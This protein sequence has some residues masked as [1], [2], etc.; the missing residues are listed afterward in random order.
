MAAATSATDFEKAKAISMKEPDF[1][2]MALSCVLAVGD[3]FAAAA[4][5]KA[6]GPLVKAIKNGNVS[7]ALKL[8]SVA[9]SAG[10]K[11]A[12]KMKIVGEAVSELSGEQIVAV[13][14]SM[15]RSSGVTEPA[16][17]RIICASAGAQFEAELKQAMT[18]MKDIKGRIPDTA[19]K[20][21][22]NKRVYPL[23]PQ[24]L[25]EVYGPAR[26]VSEWQKVRDLRGFYSREK[27]VIFL[28]GGTKEDVI[29]TLI[30]EATH[31][32]G[33]LN[34]LRNNDFMGE[35]IAHFA[36][37]DFYLHIYGPNGPLYK[38]PVQS[39]HIDELRAMTDKELLAH[40]ELTYRVQPQGLSKATR[41]LFKKKAGDTP[42]KVVEQVFAD[43]SAHYEAKV[44]W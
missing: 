18:L 10:V 35:A 23:T 7:A 14:K 43:I 19:R 2:G 30:H 38:A 34:P 12:A 11:G 15:S 31:R 41:D 16:M 9:E 33:H 39:A 24:A 1:F 26:A 27:E 3:V 5:F 13:G 29:G 40:V 42:E 8:G 20:V 37:R 36:E 21:V 25:E 28:A 32:V 17:Q 22:D 6:I 44:E 4:A